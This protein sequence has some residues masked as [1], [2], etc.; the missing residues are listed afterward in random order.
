MAPEYA[1]RGHLTY[2]A[3]VYSFGVLLLEVVAGKSNTKHHPAGEFICLVDWVVALKQKG[4]LMDLMDPRLGSDFNKKE[5]LRMIQ[6]ALLCINKYPAHR[7][8]MSEVVKMLEGHIK[9]K[10]QD[11][12]LTA[13]DDEFRLQQL[14]MKLEE[15]QSPYF[16]EPETLTN[17]SSSIRDLYPD[18]Q[19]SE[20]GYLRLE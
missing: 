6:I 13:S 19:A 18:S 7:P 15:I 10:E 9:I 2:K 3:D 20:K 1:L 8:T 12:N 5:A 11:D 14:K 17:P 4:S 16:D